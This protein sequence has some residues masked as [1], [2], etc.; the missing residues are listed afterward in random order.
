MRERGLTVWQKAVGIKSSA[1]GKG[2]T[3]TTKNS[4]AKTGNAPAKNITST[5]Y[6]EYKSNRKVAK[7]IANTV[8]KRG[9]RPD[10]A[11]TALAR[12]S[13]VLRSQRPK[14]G[15]KVKERKPR[16]KKASKWAGCLIITFKVV[17]QNYSRHSISWEWN[18]LWM[19]S[20]L[21]HAD[22]CIAFSIAYLHAS[23]LNEEGARDHIRS[24][25]LHVSNDL[26][27]KPA[28]LRFRF[29]SCQVETQISSLLIVIISRQLP[30]LLHSV[31]YLQA[32]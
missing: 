15:E 26:L 21:L 5:T 20:V 3:I 24:R 22:L 27:L 12:A 16:G 9:Y 8:A 19:L 7:S 30:K 23:L 13:A 31:S 28:L 17:R 18:C 11:R 14:T 2:I 1:S 10:L 25:C 6:A 4:I 29:C 32:S